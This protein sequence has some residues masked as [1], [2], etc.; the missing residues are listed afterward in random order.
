MF[1]E[2]QLTM[3]NFLTVLFISLAGI[4]IAQTDV[5]VTEQQSTERAKPATLDGYFS[6]L[7]F[8]HAT[9]QGVKIDL[10]DKGVARD[11]VKIAMRVMI[12]LLR[13]SDQAQG[14]VKHHEFLSE[15]G[16]EADQISAI[17]EWA[18]KLAGSLKGKE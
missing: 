16:F 9:I 1:T 11:Q 12:G 10:L 4:I 8:D 6:Q 13:R 5:V 17:D 3:K 2:F 14:S 15:K 7:G 18:V